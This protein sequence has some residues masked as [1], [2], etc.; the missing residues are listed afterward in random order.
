MGFEV[1]RLCVVDFTYI[2][3][4]SRPNAQRPLNVILTEE[5]CR[6]IIL[7]HMN[8]TAF[9][10]VVGENRS[11]NKDGITEGSIIVQFISDNSS[12]EYVPVVL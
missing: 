4:S 7:Q 9:D 11:D 12:P 5:M 8:N 2:R 3:V 10:G 6:R 1:F